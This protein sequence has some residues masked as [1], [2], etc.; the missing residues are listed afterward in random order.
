MP[1]GLLRFDGSVP[2][3]P[4]VDAWFRAHDGE[5]GRLARHWFDIIR[6]CGDDVREL[7]HDGCPVACIEDAPFASVN[8]FT[9]HVNVAFFH[10]AMLDD[11]AG[12]LRGEGKHMRH[13]KLQPGATQDAIAI[14]QLIR[15]A[16]LDIKARLAA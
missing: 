5:L 16:Y 15:A 2:R 6:S 13:V 12:V 3:D 1:T 9:A 7:V 4:A 14:E 11:A 10:G 8:V